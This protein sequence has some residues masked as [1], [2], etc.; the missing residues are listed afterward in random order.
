MFWNKI[1][2]QKTISTN[3]NNSLFISIAQTSWKNDRLRITMMYLFNSF[4]LKWTAM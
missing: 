2:N 1:T 4:R 3:N